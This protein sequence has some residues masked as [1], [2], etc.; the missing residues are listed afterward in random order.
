MAVRTKAQ[1]EAA[2]AALFAAGQADDAITP[3][4]F[5]A[6]WTDVFD[7]LLDDDTI[8]QAAL[9]GGVTTAM[10]AANAV[11]SSKIGNDAVTTAK[12]D[13]DAVTG[14]K[15]AISAGARIVGILEQLT[16]GNRLSYNNLDDQPT[17]P[18]NEVIRDV[19]AAFIRQGTDISVTHDDDGDTLT[20][21]FTGTGS[22]SSR[23]DDQV[24]ELARD[25][26]AA[27]LR[28]EAID[29]RVVI[30]SDDNAN[31][32]TLSL[33]G[34]PDAYNDSDVR[35]AIN[36]AFRRATSGPRVT[37]NFNRTAGTLTFGLDGLATVAGSG[38]YNDLTN[39][40]VI[41][42]IGTSL[43]RVQIDTTTNALRTSQRNAPTT[44]ADAGGK[45]LP[46]AIRDVMGA[47][48]TEGTGITIAVDD[49]A[50]T[51]TISA[52]GGST[53]ASHTRYFARSA[54]TTFTAAEFTGA[55][56]Q[57]ET[58]DTFN[59]PTWSG[60]QYIAFAVPDTT[61]DITQIEIEGQ[62]QFGG[63]QRITGTTTINGTAY[64]IWRSNN[65]IN[66]SGDTV[67]LTQAA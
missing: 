38:N 6:F 15:I 41:P 2:F 8:L 32:I 11:E 33:S 52:S 66:I 67:V 24:R 62:R 51:I 36:T 63:F 9:Q 49:A 64:K 44:Y 29:P 40:P 35:E 55:T 48:L 23:T 20:I 25:A 53:P 14:P 30:A 39:R 57:S 16:A 56:G 37:L 28:G 12:I 47:A 58:D 1:L 50:D 65:A 21:A 45:S 7:S 59:L 26:V 17:I 43:A 4:R 34:I 13:D 3:A 60:N 10:L 31:T 22:G 42:N 27:A 54:D 19:V 5:L 61:G 18:N 46:E